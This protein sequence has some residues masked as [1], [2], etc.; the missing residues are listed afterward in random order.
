MKAALGR[1]KEKGFYEVTIGIDNENY[2][3]LKSM[4]NS[5]GF[6]ELIKQQ[7]Y[8]YHYLDINNNP[9]YKV[10][11]F[12][13]AL[14]NRI[15]FAFIPMIEVFPE[16]QNKGI[17]RNLLKIMFELLEDITCID[18]ICDIQMQNFYEKFGIVKSHGMILRKYLEQNK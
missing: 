10:V 9:V 16:Y 11:G 3:K 5:W 15:N 18:L 6:N 1:L 14:S 4:Y 12:I 13:N 17:G 2:E 7:H 8:D